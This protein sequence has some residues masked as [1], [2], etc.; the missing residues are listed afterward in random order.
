MD[1]Q[2]IFSLSDKLLDK[3]HFSFEQVHYF[4]PPK[5]SK[6]LSNSVL[7]SA[8]WT[9]DGYY[10]LY[11]KNEEVK[12]GYQNNVAIREMLKNSRWHGGSKDE[13]PTLFS[14]FIH[15]ERFILGCHDGGEYFK[16]KDTKEIWESK[17]K[18]NEFH[19][20]KQYGIGYHFG[21]R[22]FVDNLNEIKIDNEE[23]VLYGII[24]TDKYISP[25]K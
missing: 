19:D 2:K 9:L 8:I 22:Y 11:L 18:L 12:V 7:Y 17:C 13:N 15:P 23:G 3:T 6:D 4:L 24:N 5:F 16:R 20:A 21:Y 10:N 25:K 14:L 1:I